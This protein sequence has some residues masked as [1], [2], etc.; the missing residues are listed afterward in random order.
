MRMREISENKRLRECMSE[1][2]RK[3]ERRVNWKRRKCGK[4]RGEEGKERGRESEYI[5]HAVSVSSCNIIM[6]EVCESFQSSVH[7]VQ[8]D[9]CIGG[10]RCR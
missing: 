1:R 6:R 4:T 9:Q 10:A 3:R 7:R 2:E 8:S 5:R